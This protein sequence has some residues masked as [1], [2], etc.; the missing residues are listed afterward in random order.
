MRIV[1]ET[2][3]M[4]FKPRIIVTIPVWNESVRLE[5]AV[6]LVLQGITR[7]TDNYLIVIAEDGSTDGTDLIAATIARAHKKVIHLHSDRRL[8]R[9]AALRQ[10]WTRI[11]GDLYIY[12]DCDMATDI[13]SLQT[14]VRHLRD[15]IDLVTGSRYLRGSTVSRPLVRKIFSQAYNWIVRMAFRDDVFDHQ[16][17]FK[18]FSRKLVNEVLFRCKSRHWFWDTETIVLSKIGGYKV[19]EIPVRWEEKKGKRTVFKRLVFDTLEMGMG[20]LSIW[21][22]TLPARR[23]LNVS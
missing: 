2:G 18:G 8:G 20:L 5:K 1:T 9:G 11:K 6:N 15:G 10:A 21:V 22:R 19:L 14:M 12:M 17:G 23:R 13:D 16:C 4:C 7:I 3:D